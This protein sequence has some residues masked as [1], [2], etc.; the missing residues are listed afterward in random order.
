MVAKR[1]LTEKEKA[2]LIKQVMEL[3]T[4]IEKT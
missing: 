4:I 1:M 3:R 2:T